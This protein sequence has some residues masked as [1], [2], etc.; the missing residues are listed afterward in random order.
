MAATEST[1]TGGEEM[2]QANIR[3]HSTWVMAIVA[4]TVVA[5]ASTAH[6]QKF[7]RI[8][9]V[10]NTSTHA[11]INVDPNLINA[12][13]MSRSSGSPWWIS[14]NGTGLSTLY[15][16]NGNIQGLVVRIPTPNNQGTSAPTGQ[17][18][19]WTNGFPV[20]T[21]K[22]AIF[23]FATEDGTIAAWNP[24]V[25]LNNAVLKV[26]NAGSAIYKG[27]TL[28]ITS[29]G[30][31]LYASNFKS[32]QVDVF[33][34]TFKP[35]HLGAGA[36]KL[37]NLNQ[38]WAPFGIQNVGGNV[39]VT[40]AHRKVGSHD[41]DHGPGLGW[42]AIFDRQGK[43]LQV[44][45]H[46]DWMN[47]PWGIAQSPGDFGAFSHRMLIGMFGDGTVHSFFTANGAWETPMLDANGHLLSIDG[48]WGL[49]FGNNAGAGSAIELYFT[50]GPNHESD[51]L[52]GKLVPVSTEQRGSSE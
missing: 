25:D 52:L 44:L 15:D 18:Y 26:N 13:G 29:N 42:V 11:S 37:Q 10:A 34:A 20:A 31:Y 51:G 33:D 28:A 8:D 14:D 50:A 45:E 48:L 27:L 30:P 21:G 36:F 38:D 35:V 43:L 41:E 40:F 1:V 6:A 2:L 7:N 12:W 23:L 32:G 4:I 3:R 46:G 24:G 49:T 19:N 9:L 16:G 47:A 17:V 39:V 5:L 22:K